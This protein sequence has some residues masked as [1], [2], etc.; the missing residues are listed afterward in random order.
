MANEES[1]PIIFVIVVIIIIIGKCSFFLV[2]KIRI[3][4]EVEYDDE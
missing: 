2:R 4:K 1:L 3:S